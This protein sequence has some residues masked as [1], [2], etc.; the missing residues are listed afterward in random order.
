MHLVHKVLR[1]RRPPSMIRTRCRLGL[2][3]RF[4]AFIEKLRVCPNTVDLPHR[5]HLAMDQHP[6][7][8]GFRFDLHRLQS[9]HSVEHPFK[10]RQRLV[11]S[12]S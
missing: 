11:E 3:L 5:S 12:K 2:N 10:C 7:H 4:V 9:Y 6:L 1:T 8:N